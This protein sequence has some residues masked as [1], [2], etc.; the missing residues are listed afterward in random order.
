MV[1]ENILIEKSRNFAV[2]II[3]LCKYL[4][5]S[6]REKVVPKQLLRSGTSIGANVHEAKYAQSDADFINKLSIA[7][8]EASETEYWLDIMFETKYLTEEEYNSISYDCK[9]LCKLLISI[10]VSCKNKKSNQCE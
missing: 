3:N 8:K 10:I 9:E 5:K 6:K 7:L 4:D 2:R 1:K